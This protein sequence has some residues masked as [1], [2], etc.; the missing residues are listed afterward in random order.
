MVFSTQA[1]GEESP[2]NLPGA[3]Q[4]VLGL[5]AGEQFLE[6][7]RRA[8]RRCRDSVSQGV[9]SKWSPQSMSLFQ[10]ESPCNEVLNLDVSRKRRAP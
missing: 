1:D 3:L 7:I 5:V 9:S 8:Q 4:H 10:V 2:I 6:G